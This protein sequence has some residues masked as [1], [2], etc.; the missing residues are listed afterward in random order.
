MLTLIRRLDNRVRGGYIACPICDVHTDILRVEDI[1][2]KVLVLRQEAADEE[3]GL[4]VHRFRLNLQ[5]IHIVEANA[6]Q[7][8]YEGF[9]LFEA[10]DEALPEQGAPP[11]ARQRSRLLNREP[12]AKRVEVRGALRSD[13]H[14]ETTRRRI[15]QRVH[16]LGREERVDG[17]NFGTHGGRVRKVD[18]SPLRGEA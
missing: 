17:Q 16:Q 4:P 7:V 10:G 18:A 12:A 15:G 14:V 9:I 13:E 11:Q 6:V 3:D 8:V 5:G 1:G 2:F